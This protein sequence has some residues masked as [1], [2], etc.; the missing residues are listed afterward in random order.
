MVIQLKNFYHYAD[1]ENAIN[2]IKYNSNLID[3]KNKKK[4][5]RVLLSMNHI[6]KWIDH[7]FLKLRLFHSESQRTLLLP[8]IFV[9]KSKKLNLNFSVLAVWYYNSADQLSVPRL[10]CMFVDFYYFM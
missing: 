10:N 7:L 5:E 9:A 3:L 1:S 8:F 2:K 6:F 4:E